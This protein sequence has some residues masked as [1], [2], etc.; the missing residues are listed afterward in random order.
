MKKIYFLVLSALTLLSCSND[1]LLTSATGSI[2][3]CLIVSNAAVKNAVCE[4]MGAD[5]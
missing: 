5:L 1:R 3:E 2:Y 4:T